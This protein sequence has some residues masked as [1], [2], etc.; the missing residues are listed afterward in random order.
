MAPLWS[1]CRELRGHFNYVH[2]V[3]VA[4]K[5]EVAWEGSWPRSVW[6]VVTWGP[7]TGQGEDTPQSPSEVPWRAHWL[8]K[9]TLIGQYLACFSPSNFQMHQLHCLET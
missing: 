2:I 7:T 8:D 4:D 6:K 9:G 1:A 3:N 5:A